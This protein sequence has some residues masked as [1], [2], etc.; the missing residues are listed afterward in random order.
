MQHLITEIST[1]ID[2][3]EA[4]SKNINDLMINSDKLNRKKLKI[5]QNIYDTVLKFDHCSSRERSNTS[6]GKFTLHNN[7]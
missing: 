2:T 1:K 4:R 3:L 6:F 5:N 7:F